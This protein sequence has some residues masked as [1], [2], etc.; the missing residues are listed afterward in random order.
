MLLLLDESSNRKILFLRF[1]MEDKTAFSTLVLAPTWKLVSMTVSHAR[2]RCWTWQ[3]EA[4]VKTWGANF[5]QRSIYTHTRTSSSSIPVLNKAL[6]QMANRV[7]QACCKAWLLKASQQAPL[8]QETVK[9]KKTRRIIKADSLGWGWGRHTFSTPG[10]FV[11]FC[12][13]LI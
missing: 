10:D 6:E 4:V 2:T 3:Q 5:T 12:F 13:R 1:S 8:S 9:K 7:L 11:L